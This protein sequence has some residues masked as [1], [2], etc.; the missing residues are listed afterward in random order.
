MHYIHNLDSARP[1]DAK[2]PVLVLSGYSYGAMITSQLPPLDA[3]MAMFANPPLDSD[4]GHIRS[5]A[6]SLAHQQKRLVSSPGLRVGETSPRRRSTSLDDGGF[7]GLARKTRHRARS[8][9][10][11]IS[12]INSGPKSPQQQQHDPLPVEL[13][14]PIVPNMTRPRP[15]YLLIS[16]LQGVITNLATMSRAPGHSA[17]EAQMHIHPTR[18]IYGDGDVFVS[19]KRLRAWKERMEGAKDSQFLGCEIAGAGH[20]WVEEGVLPQ[21]VQLVADFAKELLHS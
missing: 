7:R 8:S 17:A 4:A 11:S 16:P 1:D 9:L 6:E 14:L 10:G 20:F 15:A 5:R 2:A 13:T 19:V 21:M 18:A 12:S 3:V